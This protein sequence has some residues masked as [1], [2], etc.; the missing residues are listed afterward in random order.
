MSFEEIIGATQR[1]STATEALAALGAELALLASGGGDP[2]VVER[3]HAVTQAAG[4]SGLD[5]LPPPQQA[6]V[7]GLVRTTLR[8]ALDLVDQAGRAPGWAFTDPVILDGW[9]RGSAMVP[10]MIANGAPEIGDVRSLL[11]VG[12]GVGL[13]AVAATNVWPDTTVVG[14]DTWE[15]SLERARANVAQAGLDNRITLRNQDVADL[16]DVDS[17][18]CAWVP[19]FFLS[20]PTIESTVAGIVRAVRP[21][22]WIVLGRLI[23]LPD[24]LAGRDARAAHGPRRRHLPR[25]RALGRAAREGRVFRRPRFHPKWDPH[26][27]HGRAEARGV[28]GV[29]NMFDIDTLIAS[30]VDCL[31]EIDVRRAVRETLT[32]AARRPG[33][34]ADR[35]RPET[36]G[37]TL[38]YHSADLTIVD[39]V[40]APGMQIFPHDHRMWAAIAIYAGREDNEFFRRCP[41]NRGLS[42]AHGRVLTAGD[43]LMLGESALHAVANPWHCTRR[44]HSRLRG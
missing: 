4:L 26:V 38:L 31:G 44:C 32:S 11:D 8:Q 5:E 43:V 29:T 2:A 37:I 12:T 15:P 9:G 40:W 34:M 39:V 24:P 23:T 35:M 28:I 22:G 19:T 6:M 18:D 3:L 16:D 33:E 42:P 30:C 17:Y 14:V 1:W 7:L 25:R 41:D 27:V 13:L 10:T 36:A 20:E 21:G